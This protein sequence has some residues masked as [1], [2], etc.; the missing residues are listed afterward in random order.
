M[1]IE[2]TPQ[3]H[4]LNWQLYHSSEDIKEEKSFFYP[5][6]GDKEQKSANMV[7]LAKHWGYGLD[8]M[9]HSCIT[10]HLI[11]LP[12]PHLYSSRHVYYQVLVRYSLIDSLDKN[13]MW[14]EKSDREKHQ[15]DVLNFWWL[16][17][18]Y[19]RCLQMKGDS[20]L[21]KTASSR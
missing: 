4:L 20:Y 8:I 7:W 16:L 12:Y 14:V 2:A 11:K 1:A 18:L 6:G 19:N 17:V 3:S 5:C 21:S 9:G 15:I 13:R 10:C